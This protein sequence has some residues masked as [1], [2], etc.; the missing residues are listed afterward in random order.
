[1]SSD[2]SQVVNGLSDSL[3]QVNQ[4]VDLI[5]NIADQTNL[6]ALN[7]A[8]EAARAGEQGRGFAVVA[9][10]VRKLAEQS[11]HASKDINELILKVLSESKRA[12]E[13]MTEGN[14]QV[15]VGALIA[16]EAGGKFHEIIAL[17]N[18]LV[19]QVQNVAA[20]S[21]QVS[22]G[23]Q[24]VAATTEEQT[25]AMEEVSSATDQLASMATDLHALVAKY[26]L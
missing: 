12:V 23:V 19:N 10:E 5:N 6:L 18:Q 1:M 24:N 22:A 8:I 9:D 20:A 4:I 21:E 15:K 3:N 26:R 13:A 17:I 16:G 11:A 14:K 7:A 2:S 25:A